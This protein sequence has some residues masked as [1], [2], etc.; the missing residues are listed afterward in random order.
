MYISF[1]CFGAIRVTHTITTC[2]TYA[3]KMYRFRVTYH[4]VTL[5]LFLFFHVR[6]N[7]FF[8]SSLTVW[9]KG[10]AACVLYAVPRDMC[11]DR[12]RER[13]RERARQSER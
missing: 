7:F 13:V 5:F 2:H 4:R 12:E 11:T 9:L 3:L 10:Y 6:L 8:D 1:F